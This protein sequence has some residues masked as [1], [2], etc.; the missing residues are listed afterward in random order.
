MSELQTKER[1]KKLRMIG[2]PKDMMMKML[3]YKK[4][5][6]LREKNHNAYYCRAKYL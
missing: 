4:N 5:Q 2:N 3:S 6:E 1:R